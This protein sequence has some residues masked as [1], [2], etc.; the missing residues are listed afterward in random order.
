MIYCEKFTN[1]DLANKWEKRIKDWSRK[2]K[3]ALIS[4]EMDR[5]NKLAECKMKLI[6]RIGNELTLA[7][8]SPITVA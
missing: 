5:L 2:K 7:E 3:E 6:L 4:N 1:F 8:R